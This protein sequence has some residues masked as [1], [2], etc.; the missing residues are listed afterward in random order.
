MP[1]EPGHGFKPENVYEVWGEMVEY[2]ADD[3]SHVIKAIYN[4]LAEANL[5]DYFKCQF[6]SVRRDNRQFLVLEWD[7]MEA[8]IDACPFGE[9]LDVYGI[10]AIH[11]GLGDSPDPLARISK[12][13]AA[14]HRNLQVFQTILKKAMDSALE[15]LDEGWL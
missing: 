11:R 3:A 15:A 7:K 8:H 6:Y 13:N 5:A 10:L 1:A 4:A 12:L 2:A 14:E 9:H